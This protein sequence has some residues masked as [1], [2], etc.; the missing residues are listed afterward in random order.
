MYRVGPHVFTAT[1]TRRTLS[2]LGELWR[3]VLHARKSRD[4]SAEAQRARQLA[5]DLADAIDLDLDLET[6]G[7]GKPLSDGVA[8]LLDRAGAAAAGRVGESVDSTN[9]VLTTAWTTIRDIA[10]TIAAGDEARGPDSRTGTIAQINISGGGVPK[11]PI[12]R[13]DVDWGG[14]VGD[15]QRARDHHGRPWQALCLWS[16]EV[17][18]QFGATGHHLRAGAAGEN[19]T[20]TGLDWREMRPGATVVVD[21]VVLE[22][23]SYSIPCSKNAQWFDDGDFNRMHHRQG[24]VSRVY[25]TVVQPGLIRTGSTIHRER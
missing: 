1:D 4:L 9:A 8:D 13:A 5:L 10:G 15:R 23:S 3:H 14:V 25:A 7:T 16:L 11:L 12:A 6:G 20:V 21:E 24:P 17:I 2:S 19:L 22:I 18:E